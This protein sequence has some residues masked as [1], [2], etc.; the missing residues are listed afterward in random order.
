MKLKEY[1][2]FSLI[3]VTIALA[4]V[5]IAVVAI[6]GVL[7][8][9]LSTHRDSKETQAATLIMG[10][11]AVRLQQASKLDDPSEA[12]PELTFTLS[13]D[14]FSTDDL[15]VD[16][17]GHSLGSTLTHSSLY[18]VQITHKMPSTA[19][20]TMGLAHIQ[21]SWPAFPSASV[22]QPFGSVEA[23]VALVPRRAHEQ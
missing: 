3:E 13:S 23:T 17:I 9:G 22:S 18:R 11:L 20:Q 16:R 4:V 19:D 2:A 21:I 8:V 1:Q 6:V 15:Y 5:A 7:P 12:M 14:V 10:S